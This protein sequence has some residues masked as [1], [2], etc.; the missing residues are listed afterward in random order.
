MSVTRAG[1]RNCTGL[2][3]PARSIPTHTRQPD[4]LSRAAAAQGQPGD[5]Q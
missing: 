2:L 4:W 3:P 5:D 1:A